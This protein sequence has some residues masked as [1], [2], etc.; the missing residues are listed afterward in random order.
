MNLMMFPRMLT[1]HDEGWAWLMRVHPSVL[2]MFLFYAAPLSLLPP[3][4]LLYAAHAGDSMLGNLSMN[5]AWRLATLFYLAELIMVPLMAAIIQ[6]VGDMVQSRPAYHDAFTFAAVAP[7]PLW[8]SSLALFV[9]SQ[10]FNALVSV[11]ALFASGILIFEG[12]RR[13]FHLDDEGSARL[14]TGSILAAG[15]VAWAA[16][17]GLAFAGW[18]WVPA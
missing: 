7:T 3:A 2:T 8:L 10:S 5:E 18:N 16:L 14:L 9:P 12:S 11:A 1:S 13:V 6:R 15:L 17:M 4:M